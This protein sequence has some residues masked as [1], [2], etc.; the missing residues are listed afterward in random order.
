MN[1]KNYLYSIFSYNEKHKYEFLLPNSE[2]NIYES[3]NELNQDIFPVLSVNIE[4]LKSK[5]NLIINSDIKIREFTFP[6]KS[7]TISAF[8]L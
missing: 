8:L 7:K 6:I 1:I 2:N 5:Y 4:Y 3:K